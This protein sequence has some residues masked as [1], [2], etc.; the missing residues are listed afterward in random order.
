MT[1][2]K[3]GAVEAVMVILSI[4][5]THTISSMPKEILALSKSASIINLLFVSIIAIVISYFIVRL[6]K[7]F[8]RIRHY[9][10]L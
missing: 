4:V 8:P 6:L 5:V 10:Y 3:I 2:L 9:R 1:K 7:N